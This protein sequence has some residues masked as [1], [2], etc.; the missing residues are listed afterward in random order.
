[1]NVQEA[2]AFRAWQNF[3]NKVDAGKR[4]SDEL[5][6]SLANAGKRG[7]VALDSVAVSIGKTAAQFFGVASAIQAIYTAA[8]LIGDEYERLRLAQSTADDR[9]RAA[10]PAFGSAAMNAGDGYLDTPGA[11]AMT[12]KIMQA[13]GSLNAGDSFNLIGN[14]MSARQ[15]LSKDETMQAAFEVARYAGARQLDAESATFLGGAVL[16]Q[17]NTDLA[18]GR[19]P[20]YRATL[21]KFER[22]FA[23]SRSATIQDFATHGMR[24]IVGLQ[25]HHGVSEN[26]AIALQGALST[27]MPDLHERRSATQNMLTLQDMSEAVAELHAKGLISNMGMDQFDRMPLEKRLAWLGSGDE[28]A[29]FARAHLFGVRTPDADMREAIGSGAYNHYGISALGSLKGESGGREVAR[30]LLTPG[31]AVVKQFLANK[32]ELDAPKTSNED[33]FE[34][35]VSGK[36]GSP[37]ARFSADIAAQQGLQAATDWEKTQSAAAGAAQKMADDL[38]LKTG[39]G[40]LESRVMDALRTFRLRDPNQA[41]TDAERKQIAQDGIDAI[42]RKRMEK[43][44]YDD[45]GVAAWREKQGL[46]APRLRESKSQRLRLFKDYA[47]ENPDVLGDEEQNTV[48][49]LKQY[50]DDLRKNQD[51]DG[52]ENEGAML[53]LRKSI[54]Q[55]TA[56]L[57]GGQSMQVSV[58]DQAG[59]ELGRATSGPRPLE[60]FFDAPRESNIS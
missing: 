56:V 52:K 38:Q 43:L 46:P 39:R 12:R 9:K 27:A 31:N 8:H 15:G 16:D 11:R 42:Y 26:E 53:D 37:S 25:R 6:D 14:M 60:Q 51:R 35:Q 50:L 44:G 59:R 47:G 45:P 29:K 36:L 3:N 32:A 33:Y 1:M 57:Q 40:A 48:D 4:K 34:Q 19:K 49:L 20:N 28:E 10:L 13:R 18:A 55:L 5:G 24:A 23:M 17:A 41:T 7:T 2:N 58:L 22:G 21:G 54:E 30:A